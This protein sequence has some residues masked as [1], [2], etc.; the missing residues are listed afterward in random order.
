MCPDWVPGEDRCPRFV[1]IIL[2]TV[3]SKRFDH[4]A[5]WPTK[6]RN[7][8]TMGSHTKSACQF[9]TLQ[10]TPIRRSNFSYRKEFPATRFR[11][12]VRDYHAFGPVRLAAHGQARWTLPEGEFT[13]G[14]FNLQ[15]VASN[16]RRCCEWAA[17]CVRPQAQRRHC[18]VGDRRHKGSVRLHHGF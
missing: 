4:S 10:A 8:S 6:V 5:S 12:L 16:V 18:R 9:C 11:V 15:K 7:A 3:G 2:K 14:E 13:N 1:A 17:D